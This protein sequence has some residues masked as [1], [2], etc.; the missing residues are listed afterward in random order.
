[1]SV[2]VGAAVNTFG[3]GGPPEARGVLRAAQRAE[4]L[5]YESVWVG[6]HLLFHVPLYEGLAMLA[7]LA[8]VTERIRIGSGVLLGVL[9]HPAWLAKSLATID[10]L[11][12]GRLIAGLGVGG[13]YPAE[14]EASGV[15]RKERDARTDELVEV[16]RAAWSGSDEGFSGRFYD[17]PRQA[18]LPVPLQQ[19]LPI[20]VGGRSNAA[21]RRTAL[22]GDG[23]L[24]AFVSPRRYAELLEQL[25]AQAH[26]AG[27][28]ADEIVPAYHS[29]VRVG[30]THD[31]AWREAAPFLGA[32][33]GLDPETVARYCM[34]GPV[35]SIA[36]TVATYVE[37]GVDHVVLRIAGD[38]ELEQLEQL[39]EALVVRVAT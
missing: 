16:L 19:R 20:W 10:H 13:E 15:P 17:L 26:E 29:Y 8:S 33:Y 9:R 5:G 30:R 21:I 1:L 4:E 36:A 31:E 32:V 12:G 24:A 3:V 6:D 37:A 25:R 27:R 2:L 39:A 35:E 7:A 28:G 38:D 22:Q 18:L 11:A 34:C 14:F 23:W